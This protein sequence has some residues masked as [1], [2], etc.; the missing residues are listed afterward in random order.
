[1]QASLARAKYGG[2]DREL[3]S[4]TGARSIPTPMGKRRTRAVGFVAV[5][6]LAWL[7]CAASAMAYPSLSPSSHDFGSV[8]PGSS[9]APST[10][11]LTVRCQEDPPNPGTCASP[12]PLTPNVTVTGDF[13]I[14]NNGCTAPMAGNT[15][16]GTSCTFDVVFRPTVV[17]AR[18]GIVSVGDPIGFAQ[19]SV[20]GTGV[21]PFAP[22]P[23]ATTL[24]PTPAPGT[25]AQLKKCKKRHR[26]ASVAK[27][28]CRKRR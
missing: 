19:G 11:T 5:V 17:G 8:M 3:I 21:A 1:M 7:A 10:F 25:T 20:T 27:R 14:Q 9:S 15:T 24:A 18:T 26:R 4:R 23:P 28:H 13:A 16:F 22:T 12:Y 2:Y 6:A